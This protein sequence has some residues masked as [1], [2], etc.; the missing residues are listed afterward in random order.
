MNLEFHCLE[1]YLRPYSDLWSLHISLEF[2]RYS[3][4]IVY[5]WHNSICT[6]SFK[7]PFKKALL[8]FNWDKC[9]PWTTTRARKSLIIVCLATWLRVSQL[10][11]LSL[12]LYPLI[13]S[14]VLYLSMRPFLHKAP[15]C[16]PTDIYCMTTIRKR[17]NSPCAIVLQSNQFCFHGFLSLSI[18]D[19][20][21]I[22]L[23]FKNKG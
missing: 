14:L 13:S 19:N 21:M 3:P 6:T 11:K 10:S 23:G 12:W 5:P 2:C 9:H 7:S 8:M 22:W 20:L 1:S 16:R 18:V 17:H 4:L 15:R